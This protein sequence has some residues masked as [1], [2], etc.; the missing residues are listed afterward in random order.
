MLFSGDKSHTLLGH[1]NE[2]YCSNT[3]KKDLIRW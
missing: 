1:S 3:R 2:L